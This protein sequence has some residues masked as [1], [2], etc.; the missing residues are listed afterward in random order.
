MAKKSRLR[1]RELIETLH[2]A[3][4]LMALCSALVQIANGALLRHLLISPTF[5]LFGVVEM[6]YETPTR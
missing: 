4:P 5:Y 6:P 1:F 3:Q 2:C